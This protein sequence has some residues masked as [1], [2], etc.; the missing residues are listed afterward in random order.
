MKSIKLIK[1]VNGVSKVI[2]MPENIWNTIL[3]SPEIIPQGVTYELAPTRPVNTI[4][5]MPK[6]DEI[7]IIKEEVEPVQVFAKEE[8]INESKEINNGVEGNEERKKAPKKQT[9][10][11]KR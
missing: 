3:K 11:A 8:I 6:E 1:T 10:K 4:E 5:L 2:D 9:K 7:E